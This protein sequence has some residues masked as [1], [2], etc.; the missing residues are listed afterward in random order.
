MLTASRDSPVWVGTRRAFIRID[1]FIRIDRGVPVAPPPV[2]GGV[3]GGVMVGR[4][5]LPGRVAWSRIGRA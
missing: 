1:H 2:G 4:V 3:R 5:A